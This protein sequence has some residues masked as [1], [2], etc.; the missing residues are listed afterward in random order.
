MRRWVADTSPLLFLAKLN[1]LDLLRH[2]AEEIL[3]PP[4][5]FEEIQQVP[6]EARD[7]LEAARL[8]WLHVHPVADLALI[9][10][11]QADLDLGE[12]EVIALAQELKAER[13]VLDDLDARRM[14][15]RIGLLPIGTLGLLLAARLRGEIPSL[16][17][18]IERLER[19]GFRV[20]KAL[21]E[22][23]LREAGE[24]AQGED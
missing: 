17:S 8:D 20:Q 4:A 7:R 14:A 2:A 21:V 1:R 3:A 15:R 23:V 10:V 9:D 12:S 13:V 24:E 22:E 19:R 6:D 16:R 18:E 11:L 5:V